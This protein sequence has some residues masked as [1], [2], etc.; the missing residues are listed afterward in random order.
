[1]ICFECK[2]LI[3]SKDIKLK[4]SNK[5]FHADCLITYLTT[6]AKPKLTQEQA[7][8]YVKD[9]IQDI[10][11]KEEEKAFE[12]SKNK[13]QKIQELNEKQKPQE[14]LLE[15]FKLNYKITYAD[16]FLIDKLQQINDGTFE[17]KNK[18]GTKSKLLEPVSYDL[19]RNIFS[20]Y[21]KR[22]DQSGY[23][24]F[25]NGKGMTY[26]QRLHY[27]IA[28]ALGLVDEYKAKQQERENKEQQVTETA[29]EDG[30]T[31]ANSVKSAKNNIYK[32][33]IKN[34]DKTSNVDIDKLIEDITT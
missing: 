3:K 6:S 25:K 24:N 5:I 20:C 22:F 23:W 16:K 27:D 32:P 2:K 31:I 26:S 17:R 33:K 15:Y 10:K 7:E 4:Y 12:K 9:L 13:I 8:Q 34:I 21:Q 18:D 1:M 14:K 19:L 30:S 11:E 29:K 28:V